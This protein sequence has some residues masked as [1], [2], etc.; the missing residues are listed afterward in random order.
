MKM[1]RKSKGINAEREIVKLFAETGNWFAC[2]VA[3]SGSSHF[4]SP[5]IIAGNKLRK[6]AIECKTSKDKNKYLTKDEVKQL[7][8]FSDVFGA[9]PWVAVKF[10]KTVWMF[11]SLDD[12]EDAGNNYV[13]SKEK[14]EK[15]G[16]I[17]E[18][19]IK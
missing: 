10:D 6:L 12:I 3:G 17:F 7:K 13:V 19:V 9:E 5:D 8:I 15:E 1:S 18:E 2:R 4:P 11:M 14:A 16:F